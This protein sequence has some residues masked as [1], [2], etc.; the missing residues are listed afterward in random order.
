MKCENRRLVGDHLN[1]GHGVK[2]ANAAP[3]WDVPIKVKDVRPPMDGIY[4]RVRTTSGSPA[5]SSTCERKKSVGTS[6][7]R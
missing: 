3:L 5:S 4:E 2:Q 7:K 1:V 6:M